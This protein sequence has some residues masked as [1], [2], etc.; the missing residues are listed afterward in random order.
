[1]VAIFCYL[2]SS[3][4]RAVLLRGEWEMLRRMLNKRIGASPAKP[5]P[6]WLRGGFLVGSGTITTWRRA[7]STVPR[8]AVTGNCVMRTHFL[9]SQ[10]KK[11][12]IE[13]AEH[14][15]QLTE[16]QAKLTNLLHYEYIQ[17]NSDHID[18]SKSIH[19]YNR[20]SAYI[21]KMSSI[22]KSTQV[23]LSLLLI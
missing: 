2:L 17:G 7:E 12:Y 1:L 11:K 18:V 10:Q 4:E 5:E 19:I 23:V 21:R 6:D 14:L 9:S 3:E 15:L 8:C 20:L 16:L 22:H 13:K